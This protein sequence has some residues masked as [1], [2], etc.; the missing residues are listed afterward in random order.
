[1]EGQRARSVAR[2]KATP[3][4]SD[5]L[6]RDW[7]PQWAVAR[8]SVRFCPENRLPVCLWP[9]A[10]PAWLSGMVAWN[11]L[12]VSVPLS[13]CDHLLVPLLEV[14]WW[15][16][17]PSVSLS[18]CVCFCFSVSVFSSWTLGVR[19]VMGPAQGPPGPCSCPRLLR[20]FGKFE[21]IWAREEARREHSSAS[22]Q[23][24]FASAVWNL[25]GRMRQEFSAI[26]FFLQPRP[27]PAVFLFHIKM[28]CFLTL[29]CP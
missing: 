17:S 1:M 27:L 10:R 2:P 24:F 21:Q 18:L 20:A 16:P 28:F 7:G 14:P 29:P 25:A 23:M 19:G 26:F 9:A 15:A 12:R 8:A 22:V 13:S 5:V 3:G 4:R 11:L 6:P